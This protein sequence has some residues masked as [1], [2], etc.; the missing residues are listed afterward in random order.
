MTDGGSP[1][2]SSPEGELTRVIYLDVVESAT[3]CGTPDALGLR[4]AEKNALTPGH[5][6]FDSHNGSRGNTC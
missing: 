2:F 1:G 4:R 3:D 5:G 6:S